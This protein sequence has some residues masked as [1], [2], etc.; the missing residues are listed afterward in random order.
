[1]KDDTENHIVERWVVTSEMPSAKYCFRYL[2]LS[3]WW[4][5][6]LRK[7]YFLNMVIFQSCFG[8]FCCLSLNLISGTRNGY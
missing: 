3:Y 4:T 5:I 6:G 7:L 1:M 2:S 8:S